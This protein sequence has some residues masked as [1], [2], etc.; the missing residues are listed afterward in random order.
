MRVANEPIVPAGRGQSGE[1]KAWNAAL[2]RFGGEPVYYL[3]LNPALKNTAKKGQAFAD[4]GAVQ[5]PNGF[6]YESH[7]NKLMD[8]HNLSNFDYEGHVKKIMGMAEGGAA[9]NTS[10]DMSDGGLSIQAPAFKIG[11]RIPLLTR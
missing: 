10:P 7:V 1:S 6:D 4:G 11:G 2:K 5:S 9:Y 8:A 3:D